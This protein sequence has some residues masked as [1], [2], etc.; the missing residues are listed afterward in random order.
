[1]RKKTKFTAN[2]TLNAIE[3]YFKCV[4]SLVLTF[5]IKILKTKKMK[6]VL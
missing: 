3:K 6:F 1:M 5:V 2:A 4:D